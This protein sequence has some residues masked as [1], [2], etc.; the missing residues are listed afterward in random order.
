M[1]KRWYV[2]HAYSGYEKKVATS[3][4]ERVELHGM[5]DS[6]GEISRNFWMSW[7][8]IFLSFITVMQNLKDKTKLPGCSC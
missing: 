1:S 4:K 6:F 2:V 8:V 5:Q 3:L 7:K